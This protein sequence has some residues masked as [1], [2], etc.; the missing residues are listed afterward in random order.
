MDNIGHCRLNILHPKLKMTPIFHG[1]LDNL[2]FG[3]PLSQTKNK[4]GPLV[5]SAVYYHIVYKYP[6]GF[7]RINYL[8][9]WV[10]SELKCHPCDFKPSESLLVFPKQTSTICKIRYLGSQAH[11]YKIW[12]LRHIWVKTHVFSLY[13]NIFFSLVGSGWF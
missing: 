3:K 10:L 2:V 4:S 6:K 1:S 8:R 7:P 12:I 9:F 11:P 5:L 13:Q